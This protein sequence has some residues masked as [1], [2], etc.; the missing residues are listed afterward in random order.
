[1]KQ[2]QNEPMSLEQLH[3]TLVDNVRAG[4]LRVL[5]L[6]G[7]EEYSFHRTD[8]PVKGKILEELTADALEMA[9]AET[10]KE[11]NYGSLGKT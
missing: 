2:N 7:N 9:L 11:V 8:H 3:E 5:L 6:E 1:M 4:R 10:R